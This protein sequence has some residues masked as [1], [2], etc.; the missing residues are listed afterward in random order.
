M[1]TI[2]V[3]LAVS[4]TI[5]T[6]ASLKAV[7]KYDAV[8]HI[9]ISKEANNSLRVGEENESGA[10]FD[11]SM[12]LDTQ[13]SIIRSNSLA[14]QVINDFDLAENPAFNPGA[15]N[16]HRTVTGQAHLTP[17]QEADLL[18]IWS[19]GLSVAKVPRTRMIEIR[20][21]S[22][23]PRLAAQIA[24]ALTSGY[25]ERNFKTKYES[26]MQATDWL[27]KQLSDL[28]LKVEVSEQALVN[29][30]KANGIVGVDEKQNITTEKL[31]DLNKDLTSAESDRMQKQAVYE[32]AQQ[33]PTNLS[34]LA[35]N[36]LFQKLRETE[37]DLE[38]QYAQLST[39]FGPS[40]PKV[41][42][43]SNQLR[44]A[45]EAV[46]AEV[47]RAVGRAKTEYRSAF[48]R[49]RMLRS[50]LG[51]QKIAATQ[52]NEQ[53]IEYLRL[54]REAESNRALYDSLNQKL[55]EASVTSS[56]KLSNVSIVDTARVPSTPSSPN[57]RSNISL[58][59]LFGLLGGV[60]LALLL[61]TLD[62]TVR[63]PEQAEDISSLPSLGTV[64]LTL[65]EAAAKSKSSST[66]IMVGAPANPRKTMGLI[67][68]ERPKSKVAESY[69]ALRTSILL[70]SIGRPPQL[71]MLTSALP[72]EG[73]T[74]TSINTAIVLAQKGGKVLLIDADMRRPSI[75]QVFG[76]RPGNGLSTLLSGTS[77][78]EDCVVIAEDIPN[79]DVLPAG[80][81]P[82][83]P[84]ELLGSNLLR[85]YLTRWRKQYDFIVVDTPPV[86]SVTDA[87]LLSAQMDSVVLVLR[88]G[89]TTKEALRRARQ[90]F[91]KVN[92]RVL[93]V[94][95][96]AVDLQSPDAQYYGYDYGY[97]D[98]HSY[99]DEEAKATPSNTTAKT[100]V[101]TN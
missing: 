26:T 96:N 85:D 30:Q 76:I 58:A 49:E 60:G 54:K 75:H 80:P 41:L 56:L 57:V 55:K 72:Q 13:A 4:V 87:V 53:S 5:A 84:A 2:L 97:S 17:E 83:N 66:S 43:V 63:T 99:Y 25:V 24:N 86:L 38:R 32:L 64:P 36:G 95:V 40:Y 16:L 12:E 73:K 61:E 6:I 50:A 47:D 59:L 62:N 31:A 82:P 11:Y 48:D 52:L 101:E 33:E 27:S 46:K 68:F 98:S 3:V 67:S 42:E 45:H 100:I 94:V 81:Q 20:F 90:L 37:A 23:D 22:R 79:L 69:R 44:Q 9:A 89:K 29:Y 39:Q 10:A 70:S 7:R 74:T 77:D 91:D 21:T 65:D 19:E 1:W 88:S 14:L 51:Q 71:L 92:V 35:N 34:S 18:K 93:G 8:S 28:Q 15:A 78:F